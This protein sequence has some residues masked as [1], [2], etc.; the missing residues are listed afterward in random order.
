LLEHAFEFKPEI[1][2]DTDGGE[3]GCFHRL[4][5]LQVLC[6]FDNSKRSAEGAVQQG[7]VS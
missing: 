3:C 5:V 7:L 6:K 2:G 1:R 4:I